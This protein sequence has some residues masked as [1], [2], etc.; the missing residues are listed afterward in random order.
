MPCQ[1]NKTKINIRWGKL[2]SHS[3]TINVKTTSCAYW[4]PS[5]LHSQK[6]TRNVL[7][8]LIIG[9][10]PSQ[11]LIVTLGGGQRSRL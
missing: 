3:S 8:T 7:N 5:E 11:R 1:Q 6:N 10:R 9:D 4:E 2:Y